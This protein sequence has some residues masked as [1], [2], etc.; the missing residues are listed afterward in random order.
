MNVSV[1]WHPSCAFMFGVTILRRVTC[2][3]HSA[4]ASMSL[5]YFWGQTMSDMSDVLQMASRMWSELLKEGQK[6]PNVTWELK[7]QRGNTKINLRKSFNMTPSFITNWGG[8]YLTLNKMSERI[9]N[10]D[11]TR[12][13]VMISM[14]QFES[15]GKMFWNYPASFMLP[16]SNRS[17]NCEYTDIKMFSS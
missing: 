5:T 11:N 12:L 1:M 8:W 10:Y 17:T 9:C 16:L 3:T 13:Y 6:Y 4:P 14:V 2:G 15:F 7:R